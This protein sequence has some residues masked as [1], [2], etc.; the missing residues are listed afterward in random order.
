MQNDDV[1]RRLFIP[2]YVHSEGMYVICKSASC[3]TYE[4]N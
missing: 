3:C 2:T 4:H 1:G